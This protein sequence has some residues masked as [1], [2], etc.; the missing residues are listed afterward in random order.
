MILDNVIKLSAQ[1]LKMDEVCDLEELGG[2]NENAEAKKKLNLLIRCANLVINEIATD[3][4]PLIIAEEI[5]TD[6]KIYFAH[7][8]KT[9]LDVKNI[10]TTD[11]SY[12]KFKV[13]PEYIQADCKGDCTLEYSY[14]PDDYQLGDEI[15]YG[16]KVNERIIAYGTVREYCLV[17]SM[18]EDAQ[19]WDKRYKDSLLSAMRKGGYLNIPSRRWL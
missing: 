9:V 4:V 11:G 12:V 6:G 15:E 3:Y 2:S 16:G 17:N 1:L 18:Y 5:N 14:I 13:Y 19:I 10:R 8:A 7:L